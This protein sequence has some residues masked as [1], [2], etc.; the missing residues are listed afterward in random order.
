MGNSSSA[1]VTDAANHWQDIALFGL[2]VAA[3]VYYLYQKLWKKKGECGSCD[4]C[5]SACPSKPRDK[6]RSKR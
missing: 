5:A 2:I 1:L 4:S 3:A 6:E